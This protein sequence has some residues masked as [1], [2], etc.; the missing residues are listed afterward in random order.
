[1]EVCASSR[2]FVEILLH[3]CVSGASFVG[4]HVSYVKQMRLYHREGHSWVLDTATAGVCLMSQRADGSLVRATAPHAAGYFYLSR[5]NHRNYP[6]TS[7][8]AHTLV[9]GSL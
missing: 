2:L 7:C 8:L 3:V 5:G 9:S 1:M 4:M 6:I